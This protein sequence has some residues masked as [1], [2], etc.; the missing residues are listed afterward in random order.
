MRNLY[1]YTF[2]EV[3]TTYN[4][5]TN[6]NILYRIAFIVDQTLDTISSAE[7]PIENIYQI[8]IE[9]I[10]EDVEPYDR[11]VG[12]TVEHIITGFFLN[13]K[14]ALIYVCSD[15]ND[16]GSLR[17]SVFD[18]WYQNST[19]KQYIV[20]TDNVINITFEEITT[21]LYTSLLYHRDN[22]DIQ[23]ALETYNRLEEVLNNDK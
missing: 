19:Y 16:K 3:T 1:N 20:K 15:D 6:N 22:Q 21:K 7:H 2:D 17:F 23:Y 8:V 5:T 18:R 13:I 12:K 14:N 4:F 10:S 9:K 11:L